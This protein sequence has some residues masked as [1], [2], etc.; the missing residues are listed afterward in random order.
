MKVAVDRTKCEGYAKCVQAAPKVFKLDAQMI[1]EV[2]DPKG[3]TDE[4][5]MLAARICPT[6]AITV[7]E[8]TTGKKLFP[9]E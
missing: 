3:E 9:P 1:A 4:K 2:I 5:I 7:E 8:E 6:K